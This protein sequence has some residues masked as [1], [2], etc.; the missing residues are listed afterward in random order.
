M[1]SSKSTSLIL[2]IFGVVLVC[3]SLGVLVDVW[4]GVFAFGMVLLLTAFYLFL[5]ASNASS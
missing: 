1:N 4:I 3:A 2:G 5:E